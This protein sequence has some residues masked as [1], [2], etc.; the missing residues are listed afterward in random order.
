M[1]DL[2]IASGAPDAEGRVLAVTPERAGWRYVGFGAFRLQDGARL[3]RTLERRELCVVVL[4]GRCAIRSEGGEWTI[5]ERA[6]P[7]DGPPAA[8]YLPPG[9]AFEIEARGDAEIAFGSAPADRGARARALTAPR[10]EVRGSGVMERRI[11]HILMEDEP[12]ESLL[13]TEVVTPAGHWSSYPPHKHD[14]NDPPRETALEEIYDHRLRERGGFALQR[15]YTADRALDESIAVRDGDLVLVPRG[16]HT[17]SAAPG[18]ELYYLNVMAGSVRQWKVTFDV[19]H[20]WLL[21]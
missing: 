3:R 18:Y 15:V 6:T 1:S 5:G 20:R 19:D 8:A 21:A 4:G 17:V 12:S 11:H 16:Y 10:L 13:V 2:L 7:F 9:S 14:T